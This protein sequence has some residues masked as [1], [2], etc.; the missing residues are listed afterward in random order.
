MQALTNAMVR[1]LKWLGKASPDEIANVVPA[2]YLLGDRGLYLA[3]LKRNRESYSKDG[4]FPA[5]SA[6]AW[7]TVLR[8]FEPAVKDAG[9]LDFSATLTNEFTLKA[10]QKHGR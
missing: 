10:L 7:H 6:Q 5:G 4:L 8:A 2:Q 3:A 1:A 9:K